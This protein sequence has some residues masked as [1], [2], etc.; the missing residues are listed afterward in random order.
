MTRFALIF[1]AVLLTLFV[2]ELTPPG[3]RHFVQP[4]TNGVAQVST[5]AI[6]AMDP[7]VTVTGNTIFSTRNGF[8]IEILAGC[9]GVEAMIVLVAA[10]LAFP[11][12]WKHKLIGIALGVV[13][14]QALNLVRIVS[15]FYL[16]QWSH[17]AFEWAHLYLWQ[18][19]VMLD[20]LLVWLVWLRMLPP[21]DGAAPVHAR[22]S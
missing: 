10:I 22:E 9:N 15:L 12:P 11:A 5:R 18:A 14:V 19:L 3:Q 17:A 2:A 1:A 4:W 20:A 7:A 16:G 8:G 21:A 13:A 6:Q